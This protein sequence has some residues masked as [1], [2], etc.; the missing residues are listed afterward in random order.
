MHR[1]IVNAD[2]LGAS[3]GIN[4]GILEAHVNGIV[5]SASLLVD[6]PAVEEACE[7]ARAH[8]RLSLGLHWNGD[9][10]DLDEPEAVRAEVTRQLARF[11]EV[12]GSP[13][14]HVDSHHHAHRD[15]RVIGP[16]LEIVAPLGVPV[17]GE[18]DV[19]VIGGF[20]A[21]WEPGVTNL[22]YVSVGFLERLL[23]EEV[24]A[25]WTELSCHPGY[26]SPGFHSAYSDEREAEVETL[27]DPRLPALLT[28]L[29]IELASY[30]DL[31]RVR[32]RG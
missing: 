22:E 23:R 15:D 32:P 4:R 5:T 14:T 19:A 2:D 25:P 24:Q 10:V 27:T 13:P 8:D 7:L 29:G 20:Y 11:E 31:G 12:L 16:F 17:R 9:A 30:R 18:D 21:Q 6:G 26:S 1:L 28:E 3:T